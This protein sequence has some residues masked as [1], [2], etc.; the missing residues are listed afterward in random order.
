MMFSLL[1]QSNRSWKLYLEAMEKGL[2]LDTE[3]FNSLI[4]VTPMLEAEYALCWEKAE[5]RFRYSLTIEVNVTRRLHV[6]IMTR[7]DLGLQFTI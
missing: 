4:R 1:F 2:P 3:T 5:V 6:T 7:L